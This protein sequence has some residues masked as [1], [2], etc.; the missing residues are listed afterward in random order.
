MYSYSI[1]LKKT[2]YKKLMEIEES[3]PGYFEKIVEV[4]NL[5]KHNPVPY[6]YADVKKIKGCENTY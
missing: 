3:K 6:K 5:L 2:V 4:I 1:E